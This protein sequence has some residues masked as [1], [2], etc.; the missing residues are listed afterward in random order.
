MTNAIGE[1]PDADVLFVIG[2]NPTEA[3]PII[4]LKMKQALRKGAKV[5]VAD[6]RD[7]WLTKRA[8]LHLPLRPGTDLALINA[9]AHV[10]L[11]EGLEHEEFILRRTEGIDDFIRVAMEWPPERAAEVCEVSAEAIRQA[12]RE[13]ALAEKGAIYYTLG[14][15]EHVNGTQN[16]LGLANLALMTG[17]IGKPSSGVNPLRGQNNVQGACD[18]GALPDVF[19]GYQKVAVPENRRKFEEAWGVP[20]SEEPGWTLTDMIEA[21]HDGQLKGLFVMGEDPVLSEAHSSFVREAFGKLDLLVVQDIFLSATAKFADVVF[22]ASCFAEKDGTFTNTERRVQR[23]RKAVEPPGEA[24]EDWKILCELSDRLGYPMPYTSPEEVW[25]E[26]ARLSP[27]MAGISYPRIE[28]AGLQW[29][30]PSPDHPGT[31]YLHAERFTR[32]LGKF[33]AVEHREPH[34]RPSPD[35]PWLLSTGRTLYHY[36]AGTMTR[37]VSGIDET[38]PDCFVEIHPKDLDRL[39]AENG[40]LLR[41]S[42]RRGSVLAKAWATRKVRPG[43]IWM[44]FHFAEAAANELTVDAYDTVTRTAEYKVAAA[45][46]EVADA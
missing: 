15:T 44:P 45:N 9:M 35:F 8:W 6:P 5:I 16:V 36:N 20:I 43:R 46:V 19:P 11:T 22:P 42:T 7:I 29:P 33:H 18:M 40:Q 14:I 17:H 26:V 28:R 2:A 21:A 25:E 34:E 38:S 13:Y 10:I 39:G 41:V 32:G 37:R 3:H 23:V 27:S 4:G 30:C 12:A 1:I 31:R 24:R